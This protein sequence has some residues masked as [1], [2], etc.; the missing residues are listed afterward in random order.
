MALTARER[1]SVVHGIASLAGEYRSRVLLKCLGEYTG[2]RVRSRKDALE[3]LRSAPGSFVGLLGY[4]AFAR[5]GGEQAGY[6]DI[7]VGLLKPYS[8]R[9][10]LDLWKAFPDWRA[11]HN[12]FIQGC[13]KE[14]IL[15]NRKLNTGLIR[16]LYKI[17]R[18]TPEEGLF[19]VWGADVRRKCSVAWLHRKLDDVHGIGRKI[20]SFICRDTVYL[21]ELEAQVPAEELNFLQPVDTWIGRIAEF[22]NPNINSDR[23][24]QAKIAEFLAELCD[25]AGESG[26][27]GT[28][29]GEVKMISV[30][31]LGSAQRW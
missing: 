8:R 1:A 30:D 15:P 3:A 9:N 31:L 25:K 28:C 20:A 6:N 2:C 29:C 27:A 7:C 21:H 11:L 19:H 24:S 12:A 22:L 14:E 10:D 23:D 17:A 13:G 16:D 18:S 5:A 26:V 4:F